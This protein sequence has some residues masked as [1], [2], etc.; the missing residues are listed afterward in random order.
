MSSVP[1]IDILIIGGGINGVGIARD[2]VGRGLSVLVCE[3]NDLAGHTSSASTKLIHG[4]LRYLE[5]YEFGLVRKALREREVLLRAAPHIIRPLRFVMPHN[6]EL[7]PAWLIR[8]GLFLYDHLG[9]RER[10]PGSRAVDLAASPLGRPLRPDLKKG[11]V[12]S[13][14]WADDARLVVLNALDAAERGASVLPRMRLVA[15]E[16]RADHWEASLQ[17]DPGATGSPQRVRARILVNA[18][19]PWAEQVLRD[20]LGVA[21]RRSLLMAKGSHIVVPRLYAHDHAYILQNP[22]KRVGF[23]IP[24]ERDYTLIGTTDVAFDGDPARAAISPEETDYLCAMVNRYFARPVAPADVVWSYAGV[25]PLLEE[26]VSDLSAVTRDYALELEAAGAGAPL[27]SVFGGKLTTYR[28]LAEEALDLLAPH[29]GGVRPVWTANA[30]L[31]GGD[32]VNADFDAFLS[33]L[34]RHYPWLPDALR[35]RYARAYGTRV[36]RLLNGAAA[37]ADLGRDL[38]GGLYEAEVDYLVKHEWARTPEDVLWRRTKLG[39]HAGPAAAQRLAELLPSLVDQHRR[40]DLPHVS[41]A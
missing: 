35:Q 28:R 6:A 34:Q 29:L 25:R 39:L 3:Q 19:G 22:D 17:P 27:L 10:L 15:A 8:A 20:A 5:H 30:V 9:K 23:A 12:Y 38:G 36:H 32:M 11:F 18:A 24:Y 41:H 26:D 13:D 40:Q 16:R 7:R 1:T 37:P 4:G 2:A 21:P 33:D 14:A 31:P